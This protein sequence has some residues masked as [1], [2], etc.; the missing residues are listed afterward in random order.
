MTNIDLLNIDNVLKNKEV[1]IAILENKDEVNFYR[2]NDLASLQNQN[3]TVS[4]VL[5]NKIANHIKK[6]INSDR[7]IFKDVY[8]VKHTP[9]QK[10]FMPGYINKDKDRLLVFMIQLSS[11][12]SH[13]S[14]DN[15]AIKLS[16]NDGMLIDPNKE[17]CSIVWPVAGD[18]L[19]AEGEDQHVKLLF[20]N[21]LIKDRD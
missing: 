11:S 4:G 13:C 21:F 19:Q 3:V 16:K 8:F 12:D 15:K 20:F 7:A 9:S 14:I 18:A 6:Q 1:S 2:L 17:Q 5:I 10:E